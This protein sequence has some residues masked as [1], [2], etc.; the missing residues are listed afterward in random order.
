MIRE[1]SEN[2]VKDTSHNAINI[3]EVVQELYL[4]TKG[5]NLPPNFLI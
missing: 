1:E 4:S 2:M 5:L 3:D